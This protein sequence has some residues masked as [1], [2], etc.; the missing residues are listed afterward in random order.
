MS[1]FG[2]MPLTMI[3]ERRTHRM[4]IM[5]V[6]SL[7]RRDVGW[8]DMEKRGELTTRVVTDSLI[9]QNACGEKLTM[10]LIHLTTFVAGFVLAFVR[11]AR[12]A[13]VMCAAFPLLAMSGMFL[14][15]MMVTLTA[16]SQEAYAKAG[17]I[18]R[19]NQWF[20]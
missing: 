16:Q 19:N 3:A 12:L 9:L 8:F 1:Y 11:N 4:R 2:A 5:Y 13:A 14:S 18:T 17:Q 10:A 15:K 6:K 20:L 7:L